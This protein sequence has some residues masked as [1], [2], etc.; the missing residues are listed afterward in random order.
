MIVAGIFSFSH[1][2]FYPEKICTISPALKLS[3][4][5]VFDL[6]MSDMFSP[7]KGF[8]CQTVTSSKLLLHRLTLYKSIPGFHDPEEFTFFENIVG[9]GENACN[10]HF[11]LFLTMVSVLPKTNFNFLSSANAFILY[12]SDILFFGIELSERIFQL[13]CLKPNRANIMA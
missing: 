4:A 7:S 3:S 2:V 1:N 13:Y 5:N 9:K 6:K 11:L 10:Q 8:F 12:K